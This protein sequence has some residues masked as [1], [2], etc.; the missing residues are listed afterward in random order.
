VIPSSKPIEIVN[1]SLECPATA[2]LA[3]MREAYDDNVN[4]A[5]AKTRM[6]PV[7]RF[8]NLL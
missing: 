3:G 1:A 7:R 6:Y 2:M 8:I 5:P 4:M